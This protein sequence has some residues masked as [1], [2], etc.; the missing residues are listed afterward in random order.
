[1]KENTLNTNIE[2]QYEKALK[3]NKTFKKEHIED[4]SQRLLEL[5]KQSQ[6]ISKEINAILESVDESKVQD[7]TNTSND[8]HHFLEIESDK[9]SDYSILQ[10]N[11]KLDTV[12]RERRIAKNILSTKN[13]LDFYKPLEELV[14]NTLE[15]VDVMLNN[16]VKQYNIRNIESLALLQQILVD[17]KEFSGKYATNYVSKPLIKNMVNNTKEEVSFIERD[18]PLPDVD[19]KVNTLANKEKTTM[20]VVVPEIPKNITQDNIH[21]ILELKDKKLVEN[22][23]KKAMS[24]RDINKTVKQIRNARKRRVR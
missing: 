18:V 20:Q 24:K 15:K 7:L 8:L 11:S 9:L 12:M 19:F 22:K 4:S 5:V 17:E 23:T 14:G 6:E 13:I 2:E 10:I 3:K 1:M 16:D 21:E